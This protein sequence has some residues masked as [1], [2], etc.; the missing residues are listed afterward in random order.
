MGAACEDMNN[1]EATSVNMVVDDRICMV[2]V[3]IVKTD[4]RREVQ[5]GAK[6]KDG[7]KGRKTINVKLH[8]I[9]I[10]QYFVICTLE[11]VNSSSSSTRSIISREAL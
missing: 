9:F 2:N 6:Y 4:D 1:A 5:V 3:Y 11:S 7:K 10:S 8:A